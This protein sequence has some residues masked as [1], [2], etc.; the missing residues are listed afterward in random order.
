MLCRP[1]AGRRS[2]LFPCPCRTNP[3]RSFQDVA[4]VGSDVLIAGTVHADKDFGSGYK[5][6]AIVEDAKVSKYK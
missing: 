6:T 4:T 3:S 5:F 1:A 2:L